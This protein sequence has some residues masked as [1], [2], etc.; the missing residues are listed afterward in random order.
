M[1]FSQ[2]PL[3]VLGNKDY[4][5]LPFQYS[6]GFIVV[7]VVFG[8]LFPMRFILDT[9]AEHTILL[10]KEYTDILNY[11]YDKEIQV[12]GADIS[13][14]LKAWV[15]RKVP[16][17][18]SEGERIMKDIIVLENNI[19]DLS[20]MTGLNIHGILGVEF[21]KNYIVDIN[22]KEK[23]IRLYKSDYS[24]HQWRKYEPLPLELYQHKPYLRCLVSLSGKTESEKLFL[25]DTGAALSLLVHTDIDSLSDLPSNIIRGTIGKGIGGEIVGYSGKIERVRLGK[26]NF[27][28]LVTSFQ[29][30]DSLLNEDEIIRE[31]IVGNYLLD[32]FRVVFDFP[33]GK[34]LLKPIKKKLKPLSYDKSGLIIYAFGK[35]FRNYYIHHV[36]PGSPADEAGIV[37]GD[38][39]THL[40]I[41]PSRFYTLNGI[42][43]KFSGRDKEVALTITRSG[44][45]KQVRFTLRDMYAK[46]K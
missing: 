27:E 10:H 44:I 38:V 15:V 19:L 29:A 6:Q 5:T 41:W 20:A 24:R 3:S 46:G 9:G 14:M 34:L 39:L 17:Q 18:F 35:D 31:G 8:Y 7:D 33:A 1:V 43:R 11:S 4:I 12:V 36:I 23:V 16:L 2:N 21:L 45:K 22:F 40:G 26:T 42:N 37:K 25:L 13:Y 30:P 32:Q 28:N